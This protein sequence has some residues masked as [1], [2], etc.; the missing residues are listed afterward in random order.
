MKAHEKLSYVEFPSRDL[1]AT[2]TFF[3]RVFG[4]TFEDFGQ[5]YTAF[6]KQ[7]LDGGFY[8][9]DM[10]ASTNSGS[11]LLVFYSRDIESTQSRIE[12]AG[13][14]IVKPILTFPGGAPFSFYRTQW[15]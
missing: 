9:S 12:G 4:W 5:D 10:A 7:G 2:K 3:S 8:R 15:Q 13:G 1:D 14:R 11:A 6:S